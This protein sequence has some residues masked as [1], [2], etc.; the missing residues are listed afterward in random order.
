MDTAI[1]LH[2]ATKTISTA[3]ERFKD[4]LL[5]AAHFS[6]WAISATHDPA[7]TV[8]I[9][10]YE[11]SAYLLMKLLE[12]VGCKSDAVTTYETGPMTI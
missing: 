4:K 2:G 5:A 12:T 7:L 1:L 9:I 8:G 6:T 11:P 10:K 3:I